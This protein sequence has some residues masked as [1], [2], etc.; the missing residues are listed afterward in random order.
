MEI[1][2]SRLAKSTMKGVGLCGGKD[3][4]PN[5]PQLHSSNLCPVHVLNA[6]FLFFSI[7]TIE[8][9]TSRSDIRQ[10]G[11]KDC[12][13][14]FLF[15]LTLYF[16][17]CMYCCIIQYTICIMYECH[18]NISLATAPPILKL[19]CSCRCKGVVFFTEDP[20]F[21]SSISFSDKLVSCSAY[22]QQ[23]QAS[24]KNSVAPLGT[25]ALKGENTSYSDRIRDLESGICTKIQKSKIYN[26]ED[27]YCIEQVHVSSSCVN[28]IVIHFYEF[29]RKINRN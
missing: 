29:G 24:L 1:G 22:L 5:Q 14:F 7:N 23:F 20:E 8:I 9:K 12:R 11:W 25:P 27:L 26:L 18:D 28:P 2:G 19:F 3:L 6:A 15:H 4:N 17:V 21:F 13:I 10:R 16:V